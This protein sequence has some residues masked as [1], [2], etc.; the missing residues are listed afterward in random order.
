MREGTKA[1][2]F[3]A[4]GHDLRQPLQT[5]AIL[6]E[7]LRRHAP[8][9]PALRSLVER[10]ESALWS[11]RATLDGFLDACRLDSGALAASMH[12]VA[13]DTLLDGLYEDLHEQAERRAIRLRLGPRRACVLADGAL[14]LRA[15][16]MLLAHVMGVG[17]ARQVLIGC[18][19]RGAG[20][21]VELWFAGSTL[22]ASRL[23]AVLRDPDASDGAWPGLA[24]A[25][26]RRCAESLSTA[27]EVRSVGAST[28]CALTLSRALGGEAPD[29]A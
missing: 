20:V 12:P 15:L 27:F 18:R 22:D 5:L 11:M 28:M 3:R 6:V 1:L 17:G 8:D 13:L 26:A 19:R 10:Q 21:R 25:V 16:T 29:R 4:A 14:L 7:L 23:A 24:L 2:F 9:D